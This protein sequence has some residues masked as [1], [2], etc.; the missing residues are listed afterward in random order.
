LA[1]LHSEGRLAVGDEVAVGIV[2]E[3]LRGI[4]CGGVWLRLLVV[5]VVAV[6]PSSW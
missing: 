5:Y 2:A 4:G 6:P 1:V 3:V